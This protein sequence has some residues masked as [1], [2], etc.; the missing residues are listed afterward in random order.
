MRTSGHGNDS[1]LILVPVG[2][3]AIVGVVLLVAPQTR[4]TS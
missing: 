2:V 4:S 3:S 1:L